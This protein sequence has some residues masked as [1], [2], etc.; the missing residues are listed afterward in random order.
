M[1]AVQESAA[2]GMLQ[3][4]LKTVDRIAEAQCAKA[5][6]ESA[7]AGEWPAGLWKALEDPGLTRAVLPES[8]G[9]AGLEP[10]LGE[11]ARRGPDVE[12][13]LAFAV[14]FPML[15]CTLQFQSATTDV[16]H[17]LAE[18]PDSR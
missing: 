17:V 5:V 13:R 16:P 3:D 9:G 18:H 14:S 8:A 10:G 7:E 15:E 6:R 2:D 12:C 4:L 11:A 1:S